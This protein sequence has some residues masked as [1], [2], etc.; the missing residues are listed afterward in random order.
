[1]KKL[2][3]PFLII[4]AVFPIITYAGNGDKDSA[5]HTKVSQWMRNTRGIRFLENK[6]QMM[7][8]QR[9]AVNNVLFK[10]GAGGVDVYVTTEGLSYVFTKMEKH[11]KAG[12][13]A[14][15]NKFARHGEDDSLTIQYCRADMELVGA[16]IRKENIVKEG[17][18]ENRTDYYYGDICPNGILGVHSYGKVTIKNIY[19]GID[20]VLHT[21]KNGLK[22]DFVVHPGADPSLI[23]LK[24]KWTDKPQLQTDGSIKIATPMGNI[25]EGIPVSYCSGEKIQTNYAVKD[26]EIHFNVG[27]YN[28]TQTLTID[29]K[30]VWA[31]YYYDGGWYEGDDVLSM[32]D[33]GKN[34][35]I[36][37]ET[38]SIDFPTLNPGGGAYFQGALASNLVNVF[39]LQFST[40]GIRKWATYYGGSQFDCGNSINSDGTNVWL[41]GYTE[42]ASFP[43]FNPGAGAYFQ[44]ALNGSQN[45]FI[46]EFDTT[47]VRKWATYYGGNSVESGNSIYSDGNNIWI[48]GY[49]TST[50]FPILN[51]G[52]K[53]YFQS[54]LASASG[55]VFILQFSTTG[56]REWA[57]YYGGSTT[58]Y[59]DE[60]NSIYSDGSN[61][62]VTGE[63]YSFDFPTMNPG[64]GAYFQGTLIS[65]GGNAFILKFNIFG[66]RKWATYYGG[67]IGDGGQSIYIDS[68]NVWVTGTTLSTN[69]P[70]LNPGNRAYFQNT[71][72]SPYGDAFIL[73]FDTTGVRKWATYY[74]GSGNPNNGD[75]GYSIQSDGTNVW[76]CGSTS[77]SDFPKFNPGCGFYQD[78]MVGGINVFVLQFNTAGVRKW[79][80]CYGAD[81]ENDGS[82]IWSD[83]TNLFV[84]GD[85]TSRSIYPT[86]NP[87]GGAYY[88]DT[89]ASPGSG[90]ESI[91]IGKFTFSEVKIIPPTSICKGD[92]TTI[93]ASGA[94]SYNWSPPTGL[95]ATNIANPVA[96]PTVTTT[97]TVIGNSGGCL[98]TNTV[99]VKVKQSPV[100]NAC[101]DTT[102]MPG[103]SVHLSSTGS[104]SYSW[105]P[106]NGLSCDTC[107]DPIASP[108]V[109]TWY[110]ITTSDSGCTG[111]E[112]LLITV[113]TPS[114]A[115][116]TVFVPNIFS[117]N[118]THNNILYVRGACI[119]SMDFLVFDRW[120]NKVFESQNINDGWDGTYKG[121][122]MNTAT[123][124]WS[125]K[126]TLRDGASLE[127][128]GDVTLVR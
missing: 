124:V 6:G 76:V 24:Y 99:I 58:T 96:N 31:T 15:Q 56:V 27:T 30:L 52:G 29:P 118:E 82:Y 89:S 128:K 32:Q 86:L 122:A 104:G 38:A 61:V 37:G 47:G 39:I 28:S 100:V 74:G 55:N 120:G 12:K 59:S 93:T 18:S 78:T 41:T 114:E 4:L 105:S 127:R 81:Y 111:K 94:T 121:Q 117:P 8:M 42:S 10:A 79:A 95:S 48:A 57:T 40:T 68:K 22:Y 101:C 25:T 115:C 102:L 85:A 62:W 35:W 2:F 113:L 83:G 17:E 87:G 50:D 73:Q 51:P 36:T 116:G 98:D 5:L 110:Y 109:T 7:D 84:A 71:L 112:S 11:K 66:E 26:G 33:D 54:A 97:Y 64:A 91:F 92:S 49:T 88:V 125:L 9:K 1:V 44:G 43:T 13:S 123:Y 19:P 60:G 14:M 45:A 46:L 80:T 107:P 103:Q 53:S 65:A 69:F 34:V 63:T 16:D 119:T 90:S 77:S 3:F 67:N 20:W 126:A 21:G 75:I 106:P 70:T 108:S 23:R 72:A